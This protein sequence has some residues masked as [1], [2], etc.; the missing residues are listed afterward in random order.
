CTRNSRRLGRRFQKRIEIRGVELAP[1]V[2]EATR[3][4]DITGKDIIPVAVGTIIQLAILGQ[5]EDFTA[6]KVLMAIANS[7]QQTSQI[8]KRNV[9][10]CGH[11]SFL[12]GLSR[13]SS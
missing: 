8:C 1:I 10:Y 11:E 3:L 5:M 9:T 13:N 12:L 6:I 2:E 4:H 7:L